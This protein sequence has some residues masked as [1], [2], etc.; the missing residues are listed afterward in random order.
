MRGVFEFTGFAGL[1]LAL[2]VAAFQSLPE[3]SES[4]GSGGDALVTVAAVSGSLSAMVE[5]W[6]RPPDVTEILP[7]A[8]PQPLGELSAMVETTSPDL[9]PIPQ[10]K[11]PRLTTPV[12]PSPEVMP[13]PDVTRSAPPPPVPQAELPPKVRPQARPAAVTAAPKPAAKPVARQ[14][15]QAA[16]TAAGRG[17]ASARGTDGSAET[18]SLTKAARQTLMAEWGGKIRSRI[19]RAKPRGGGRGSVTVVLTVGRDGTLQSAGIAKSS[20]QAAL[21]QRAVQAVRS[22]G[23]LPAAPKGLT[24][25]SYT[26]RLPI[27]FD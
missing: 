15:P 26:F 8:L 10:S 27:R 20:G 19:D 5:A 22:A 13:A 7:V 18:A 17:A 16:S 24:E 6:D 3:G 4:A 25:A 9:A 12:P 1:A 2:H 11:A 14:A 21:D 23:R